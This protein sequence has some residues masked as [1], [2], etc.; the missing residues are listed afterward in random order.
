MINDSE[1]IRGSSNKADFPETYDP[2]LA[3]FRSGVQHE[4]SWNSSHAKL[5]LE[6]AVDAISTIFPQFDCVFL[7]DQSSGHTKMQSDGLHMRNMNVSHGGSAEIMHATIIHEVG[8][9]P[10]I[11]HVGDN[12]EKHFVKGDNGP[13]WM[14]LAKQAEMKHDR[15]LGTAKTRNKTKIELLKDLLQSGHDTRKERYLKAD[16]LALCGQRN[17]LVTFEECQ[18]KEGWLGKPKGMLHISLG[19]WLD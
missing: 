18:V 14:T 7:F 6:D 15:Q 2:C 5:Q 16:L 8:P 19:A 13:F 1:L 17:I 3:F 12:Q 11:L 9:H 4:G 10:R